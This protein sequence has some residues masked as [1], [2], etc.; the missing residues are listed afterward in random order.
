[1]NISEFKKLTEEYVDNLS[2][3]VNEDQFDPFKN[4]TLSH[5]FLGACLSLLVISS[6]V[7]SQINSINIDK[8]D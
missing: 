6:Y 5:V 8:E 4:C 7:L 2:N 3:F 1:M